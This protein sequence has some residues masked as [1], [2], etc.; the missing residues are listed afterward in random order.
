MTE[1]IIKGRNDLDLPDWMSVLMDEDGALTLSFDGVL[2]SFHLRPDQTERL[3]E[4]MDEARATIG[5]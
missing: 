1:I 2:K 4:V 3:L 5:V